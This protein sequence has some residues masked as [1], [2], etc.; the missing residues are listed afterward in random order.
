MPGKEEERQAHNSI[1]LDEGAQHN[2]EGRHE[3]AFALDAIPCEQDDG[4]NGYVELLHIEGREQFM[5]AEPQ[6]E[7][8]LIVGEPV[9][10]HGDI[11]E[12]RQADA[13]EQ[14]SEPFG[15]DGKGRYKHREERSV[16]VHV[17]IL[18][19]IGGIERCALPRMPEDAAEDKEVVVAMVFHHG[20]ENAQQYPQPQQR[21]VVGKE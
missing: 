16:V 12:Q 11:E 1:E 6:D 3:V 9:T 18:L 15:D 7:Q 13:P 2:P 21:A 17:E 8:L 4:G 20:G 19:R 14:Q 10:A 5:G